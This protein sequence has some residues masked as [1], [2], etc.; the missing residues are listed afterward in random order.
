MEAGLGVGINAAGLD[1]GLLL[2]RLVF[3]LVMVAHGSQKLFGW[4]G[5][6]GLTAVSGFFESLGFR[7]GRV[8]ATAAS[9]SEFVGG[10][11]L[12]LGFLGPIGPALILSIMIV[13]AVTVHLK[14]G[15]FAA[16]NGIEVPLLYGTAAV[17]LALSGFGL[18]SFDA[19]LGATSLWTPGIALTVLALGVVSA[20]VVLAVRRPALAAA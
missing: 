10:L 8:F 3:G 14:G 18:Y 4:F 17:M 2:G 1:V 6:Y 9:V 20:I 11:L 7:P 12:A 5:G 13:A 15:L 16:N 19:A